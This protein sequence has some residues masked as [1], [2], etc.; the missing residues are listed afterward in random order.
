[1]PTDQ[2]VPSRDDEEALRSLG[3]LFDDQ[4]LED[5]LLLERGSGFLMTGLRRATAPGGAEEPRRRYA[6]VESDYADDEVV[7]A[8]VEGTKRRGSKH[9]ADRNEEG[10]RLIGRH[11]NERGGRRVLVVDQGD[12]FAVRMLVEADSDTPHHFETVT[13]IELERMRETAVGSRRPSG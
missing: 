10:L 7:A 1:M 11:V 12:A 8:S 13:S 4:R 5:V 9:R 2:A 3:R 6:Y